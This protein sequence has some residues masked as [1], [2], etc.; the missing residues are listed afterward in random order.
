MN[1][2]FSLKIYSVKRNKSVNFS[3]YSTRVQFS[4][5]RLCNLHLHTEFYLTCLLLCE[6]RLYSYILPMLFLSECRKKK[7]EQ[8]IMVRLGWAS[9]FEP[10]VFYFTIPNIDSVFCDR[11]ITAY[12]VYL[13][14]FSDF[15]GSWLMKRTSTFTCESKHNGN[16][17][18]EFK[19]IFE[20]ENIGALPRSTS[21]ST[22]VIVKIKSSPK[23]WSSKLLSVK[24]IHT[25]SI[26]LKS[27]FQILA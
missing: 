27:K 26:C 5:K 17:L 20:I 1:F 16:V 10:S 4:R 23:M 3:F 18:V 9:Y 25:I 12:Q 11:F 15:L 6:L 8:K 14:Y 19:A 13:L 21:T 2:C 22:I 24:L 7:N